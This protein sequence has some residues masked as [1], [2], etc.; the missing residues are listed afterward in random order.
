[1]KIPAIALGLLALG[2][3]SAAQAGDKVYKW[4]DAAGITHF[5]D[6]PPPKGT[7]FD[8]IRIVGQSTPVATDTA[9]TPGTPATPENAAD[10]KTQRCKQARDK[11]A[12]LSS[13]VALTIQRE[14]KTVPLEGAE[15]DTQLKIATATADTY[16]AAAASK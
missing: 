9:S 7:E 8:N 5:T 3:M 12:L 6:T 4:K 13:P 14:G 10:E 1:M 2:A 11:V 16:C 15:R